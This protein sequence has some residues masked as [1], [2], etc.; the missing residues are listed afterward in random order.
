MLKSLTIE[1]PSRKTS[2]LAVGAS[3]G[4]VV[5]SHGTKIR[6]VIEKARKAGEDSPMIFHVPHQ[7]QRYIY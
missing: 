7:G 3:G 5:I 1:V 4:N 6:T 2:V